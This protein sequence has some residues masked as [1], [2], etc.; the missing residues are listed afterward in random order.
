MKNSKRVVRFSQHHHLDA[1]QQIVSVNSIFASKTLSR[2]FQLLS[3]WLQENCT[4]Y[5]THRTPHTNIPID[6]KTTSVSFQY[7]NNLFNV[8]QN[9]NGGNACKESSLCKINPDVFVN[10]KTSKLMQSIYFKRTKKGT[11]PLIFHS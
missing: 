5:T 1:I 2:R 7:D 6:W 8:Y 3:Q 4:P 11:L 10:I 9:V